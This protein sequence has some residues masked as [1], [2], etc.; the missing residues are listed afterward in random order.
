MTSELEDQ[1]QTL[2]EIV[3][4]AREPRPRPLGLPDRRHR[5]RDDAA[6]QPPRARLASPSGRACCATCRAVDSTATFLGRPVRLPVMLAP[7]G[8]DGVL[9]RRTAPRRPRAGRGAV[10]R[11]ADALLGLP[12]R[13]GGHGGGAPTRSASS[14]STCAATTPGST[15]GRR[16]AR[17]HGYRAFC[18]TVDTASYSR[19]ERDLAGASSSRGARARPPARTSRPRSPGTRSSASRTATTCR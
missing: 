10:R 1:F 8:V 2:H 12:A 14:S 7:V 19:R 18:F 13:A 5:D 15:T 4:A 6:A 17:E 9:R 11:A 3:R 16:R